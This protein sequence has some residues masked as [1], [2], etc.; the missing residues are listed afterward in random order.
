MH[1]MPLRAMAGLLLALCAAV[2]GLPRIADAQTWQW[3]VV[4]RNPG[5]AVVNTES[6]VELSE[7][8]LVLTYVAKVGQT[9]VPIASCTAQV[10]DIASARTIH[11][12]SARYLY[13]AFKPGHR[14]RCQAGVQAF[15]L[16]P[17][18]DNTTAAEA[19]MTINRAC[20]GN[21]GTRV[22]ASAV[23]SKPTPA[24]TASTASS[25]ARPQS[26]GSAAARARVTD[27]VQTDGL[28]TYV[29][30]RN[31]GRTPVTIVR[32][33]VDECSAVAAGCGQFA[34]PVSLA[35]GA[36]AI[37]ATVMST[38]STT[39]ESFS[40]HF[41]VASGSSTTTISG[42]SRK[43]SSGWTPPLSAQ[44]TRSAQAVA[45]AALKQAHGAAPDTTQPTAAPRSTPR[46]EPARLTQRGSSRL[47]IGKKGE[48]R[49]RVRVS[50]RGMPLNAA[51]VAVSNP[52][53]VAAALEIAVSSTYA[54]AIQNGR[55]VDADYIA[56]FQFDGDDPAL[57]SIPVW[58]RPT[59]APSPSAT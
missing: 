32:G 13:V 22:A 2:L 1:A 56:A 43:Q 10:R 12:A 21:A 52:D 28:F 59:P 50:A 57:S 44:E 8:N 26:T 45:V 3:D 14:A 51:I 49:V 35:P 9:D 53:L 30:V 36:A 6:R 23:V 11:A 47:A 15:A 4:V 25:S 38:N 27:W 18:N 29:R 40:Y 46:D 37:V 31:W 48:A 41:D 58:E 20:C 39:N 5:S 17:V 19:A 42:D 7:N 54:P 16:V 33:H 34:G 55:P 24:A